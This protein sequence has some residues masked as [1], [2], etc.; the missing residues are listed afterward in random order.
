MLETAEVVAT[1]YGVGRDMQDA[2][3]LENQRR[4]AAAHGAGRFDAEIVPIS[5]AKHVVDR[6][7]GAV[8]VEDVTL[9]TD[10]CNRP[11]NHARGSQSAG[12]GS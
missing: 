11:A 12:S 3:A 2:Y 10:E 5:T 7:T 4:T 6:E 1:R 8:S 9:V